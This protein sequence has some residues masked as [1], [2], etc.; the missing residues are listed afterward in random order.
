MVADGVGGGEGGAEASATALENAMEYMVGSMDCY[1]RS[2]SSEDEFI[3]ALQDAATE[4]HRRGARSRARS[5]NVEGRMATTLTLWMSVWP[6]DL[7]L[8]VG[9]SRYYLWRAGV[10]TQISR[11]QT[12]AQELVDKGVFTRADAARSGF[13]NVLS[14]SIGGEQT[15]PVVTRVRRRSGAT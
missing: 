13:A 7:L 4:C 8:Q 11:D 6:C 9:D 3:D 2:D 10:L 1:Y 14:S 12:I 15:A 5:Q